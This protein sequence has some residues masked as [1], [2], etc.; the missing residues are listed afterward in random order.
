MQIFILFF[1]AFFIDRLFSFFFSIRGKRKPVQYY[2]RIEFRLFL[3]NVYAIYKIHLCIYLEK[4]ITLYI[5][6]YYPM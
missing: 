6:V 1:S 3:N 5:D 2:N 4:Y